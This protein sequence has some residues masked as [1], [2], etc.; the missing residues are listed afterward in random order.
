[1]SHFVIGECEVVHQREPR[2]LEIAYQQLFLLL[3]AF[4]PYLS[5]AFFAQATLMYCHLHHIST[6]PF[7]FF[8]SFSHTHTIAQW[9]SCSL[10]RTSLTGDSL[11]VLTGHHSALFKECVGKIGANKNRAEACKSLSSARGLSMSSMHY[12]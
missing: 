1:M 9:E 2:L 7:Y 12:S 8:F 10:H 11:P 3:A 6:Q 4:F 5:R